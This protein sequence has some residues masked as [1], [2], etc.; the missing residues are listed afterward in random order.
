MKSAIFDPCARFLERKNRRF[1]NFLR[2]Y[3]V[4]N[5]M[6]FGSFFSKIATNVDFYSKSGKKDLKC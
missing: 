5:L 2:P 4:Q 3:F 1:L 6:I